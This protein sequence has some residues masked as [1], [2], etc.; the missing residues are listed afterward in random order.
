MSESQ[1]A[2]ISAEEMLAAV[3]LALIATDLAGTIV[4]WN[5]AAEELFG[6]SAQEAVGRRLEDVTVPQ[7]GDDVASQMQAALRDR[8]PWSG[9]S[10]VRQKDGT[11][12]P[13][14]VTDRGIYRDGQL[15]GLV[16]LTA[17]LGSALRPLLERSSD[18]ALVLRADAV[19][20]YASPSVSRLF[21]WQESIV[22][23]S[24]LPL[25]HPDERPVLTRSMADVA[26]HPKGVRSAA[27]I[28]VQ[29][30]SGWV[31]TEAAFTSMLDDSE[32]RGVVCNLRRSLRR[33]A[34]ESAE[35]LAEQL[36][37]ALRSR[38]VIEQAK[39]FLT[40][41]QGITPD[42][43]FERLRAHA[44]SHNLRIHEV[45]RRVMHEEIDLSGS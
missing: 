23:S 16:G 22:G 8:L 1:L 26:A 18:A 30:G 40:G 31:W 36:D 4:F 32:V 2:S 33:E 35:L 37:T 11:V 25:L 7:V 9:G 13:A 27:E 19:V 24:L 14:L 21:G 12:I 20:T 5:P 41:R 6:W 10:R 17:N 42:E 15:I 34:H 45:A 38:I 39:G 28:R 44:R 29:T 43:G 3:G